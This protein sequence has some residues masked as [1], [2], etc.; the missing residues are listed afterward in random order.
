MAVQDKSIIYSDFDINLQKNRMTG[1]IIT[2]K[3]LED[4]RQSIKM[5]L[6]TNFYDRKWNPRFGSYFPRTLFKPN[7]LETRLVIQDSIRDILMY[8]SRIDDVIVDIE[9][10]SLEDDMNGTIRIRLHYHVPSL[11]TQDTFVFYAGKTR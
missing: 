1:D 6:V 3:N 9:N 7:D 5:L 11:N 4:I 8:E 2:K 10:S